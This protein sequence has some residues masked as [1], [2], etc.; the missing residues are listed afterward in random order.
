MGIET[1][2]AILISS[3]LATGATAGAGIAQHQQQQKARGEANK[4]D[5]EQKRAVERARSLQAEEESGQK[6]GDARR[7]ARSRQRALSTGGQSRADTILTSPLGTIS[8]GTGGTA[9]KTLLGG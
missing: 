1:G 4:R 8:S 3:L 7:K 2:T 6:A 5:E 9:Q